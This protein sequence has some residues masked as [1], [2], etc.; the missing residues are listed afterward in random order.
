MTYE[1][2]RIGR[3]QTSEPVYPPPPHIEPIGA[4]VEI[5]D[6]C[7]N[8]IATLKRC[9]E[10]CVWMHMLVRAVAGRDRALGIGFQP[11]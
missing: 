5:Y 9:L 6:S 2:A 4:D 11:R 1:Y 7:L 10:F 3:F 8:K